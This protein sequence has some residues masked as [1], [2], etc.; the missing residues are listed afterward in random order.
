MVREAFRSR[1]ENIVRGQA[2]SHSD[3]RDNDVI[4]ASGGY[5][6]Q[7]NTS[8]D[9]PLDSEHSL[10]V[11]QGIDTDQLTDQIRN[12]DS[13][14]SIDHSDQQETR[15]QQ[16]ELHELITEN[17][18]ENLQESIHAQPNVR[19]DGDWEGNFANSF[20]LETDRDE[21][22]PSYMQETQRIWHEAGSGE[23]VENL[24]DE[25]SNSGR[26]RHTYPHRR[27]N[28]SH[29]PDDDNVYSIELRELL[30]R[31]MIRFYESSLVLGYLYI[32][33]PNVNSFSLNDAGGVF[34]IFFT[35]TFVKVLIS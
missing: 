3:D 16:G 15:N 35:V 27:H 4:N 5:Q 34:Q 17:E 26:F 18:R 24:T 30:S 23:V 13:D 22:E 33:N 21:G 14:I 11:H 32:S 12:L 9:L 2:G 19:R 7:T 31:Y 1:L 8:V 20:P 28:R 10:P 6:T 25:S 29:P